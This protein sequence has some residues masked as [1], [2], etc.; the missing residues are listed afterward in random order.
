MNINV[1]FCIQIVNFWITYAILKKW[2]LRPLVA[3][4]HRRASV[5]QH[6][7]ESLKEKELFLKKKVEEKNRSFVDFQ[8]YLKQR[9]HY[10][11]A[12]YPDIPVEV[13][14]KRNKADIDRLILLSKD[15]LVKKVV[16]KDEFVSMTSYAPADAWP[17]I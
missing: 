6:L 5:Q 10:E 13:V 8:I 16:E 11:P 9:Y 2:L 7:V 14:Y 12:Q 17:E 15:L 4:L 3:V 1:T